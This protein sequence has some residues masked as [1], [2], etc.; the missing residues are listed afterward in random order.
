MLDNQSGCWKR[1]SKPVQDTLG[2]FIHPHEW[3]LGWFHA[4]GDVSWLWDAWAARGLDPRRGGRR[5]FPSEVSLFFPVSMQRQRQLDVRLLVCPGEHS[6]AR[7]Q[8][9]GGV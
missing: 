4:F 3:K 5:F 7:S 1:F 8:A 2:V 9:G 6:H